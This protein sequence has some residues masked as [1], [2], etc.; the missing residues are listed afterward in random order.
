M[1]LCDTAIILHGATVQKSISIHILHTER[2]AYRMTSVYTHTGV[3]A[4]ALGR[5][6]FGRPKKTRRD[7]KCAQEQ[8][9]VIF[10][11]GERCSIPGRGKGI[12]FRHHVVTGRV[13]HPVSEQLGSG[14]GLCPGLK[15]PWCETDHLHLV[16]RLKMHAL[17]FLHGVVLKQRGH[18]TF[19][20]IFTMICYIPHARRSAEG[21]VLCMRLEGN[22]LA[23][24]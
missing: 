2:T 13:A 9:V 6:D 20:S 17:L 18:F 22:G 19:T 16:A 8:A 23:V 10:N 14:E 7:N 15:L 12:S 4:N 21:N 24:G 1:F 11:R 3:W 5:R